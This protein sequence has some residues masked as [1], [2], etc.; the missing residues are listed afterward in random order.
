MGCGLNHGKWGKEMTEREL[1]K[2]WATLSSK[3]MSNADHEEMAANYEA[4]A[5]HYEELAA[6]A[7]RHA[8]THRAQA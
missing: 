1:I 4:L 8:G 5:G 6:E 2:K 7:R 3:T